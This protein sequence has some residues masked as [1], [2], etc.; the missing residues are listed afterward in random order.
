[1]QCTCDGLG[2]LL[3]EH[4]VVLDD[5]LVKTPGFQ[6]NFHRIERGVWSDLHRPVANRDLRENLIGVER[7]R[8]IWVV[9]CQNL[10]EV[11][12]NSYVFSY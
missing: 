4:I 3:M 12:E 2:N 10:S 7:F 8:S 5:L 1:M 11:I 6:E 9:N